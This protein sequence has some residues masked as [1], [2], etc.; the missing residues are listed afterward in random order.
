MGD[1]IFN[2]PYDV[3][4]PPTSVD[5]VA[6]GHEMIHSFYDLAYTDRSGDYAAP[7]LLRPEEIAAYLYEYGVSGYFNGAP[8]PDHVVKDGNVLKFFGYGIEPN[9][10]YLFTGDVYAR[11]YGNSFILQPVN[12]NF[13][14]FSETGYLFNGIMQEGLD[15]NVTYTGYALIL[16][17]ANTAGMLEDSADESNVASLSLYYLD[18]VTWNTSN[19]SPASAAAGS[20][21]ITT[22]KTG[23]RTLDST[24]FRVSTE[25]DPQTRAFKVYL[26]GMLRATVPAAQVAGG[27]GGPQGFGFYTGYY[28]HSC[29]ILTRI[30][31]EEVAVSVIPRRE[32]VTAQVS[33]VEKDTDVVIRTPETETG[34]PGQK[35]KIVQPEKIFYGGQEYWLYGNS[36]LTSRESD[37][38]TWYFASG[39]DTTLYYINKNSLTAL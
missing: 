10:D 4:V 39:N 1:V 38:Q 28:E 29:T 9:M 17:C 8:T 27:A 13:H 11:S 34:L 20:T 7:N 35:Y 21:L 31:Y 14:S 22:I 33:F 36:K 23:I 3:S 30:Y 19:F 26:D 37:I 16:R 18:H 24:P 25:I 12:M 5:G 2:Y 6:W 32:T 15:N